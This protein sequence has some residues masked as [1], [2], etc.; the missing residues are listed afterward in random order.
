MLVASALTGCGKKNPN[1][2]WDGNQPVRYCVDAGGHRV[3][4]EHC[5][6]D[7]DGHITPGGANGF[8]WYYVNS[9]R[10]GAS[11]I[12]R[13]GALASGGSYT[14]QAGAFYSSV[15]RGGFGGTAMEMGAHGGGAGE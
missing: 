6:S 3:V 9:T 7:P 1:D 4:D 14:P 8:L 15:S 2:A 5:E 11:Y 12:P 13:F 10:G